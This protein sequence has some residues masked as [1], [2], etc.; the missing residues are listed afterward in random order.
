MKN[1]FIIDDKRHKRK[2]IVIIFTSISVF[3]VIAIATISLLF[4]GTSSLISDDKYE[5]IYFD[6]VIM[7]PKNTDGTFVYSISSLVDLENFDIT[8]DKI[9]V[10]GDVM[11]MELTDKVNISNVRIEFIDVSTSENVIAST[12]EIEKERTESVQVK[13]GE[14][15]HVQE[16]ATGRVETTYLVIYENGSVVSEEIL[17]EEVVIPMIKDIVLV[18]IGSETIITSPA[19]APV[20]TYRPEL[21][22]QPV[23]DSTMNEAISSGNYEGAGTTPPS[24]PDDCTI[25]INGV[26]YPCEEDD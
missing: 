17:K 24:I 8:E 3:A 21:Y 19:T 11:Q 7:L 16:G 23:D 1:K 25:T 15:I 4:S 10:D 12:I 14:E 20:T 9:V 18:G 5:Y 13:K 2:K 26:E 6:K 22:N